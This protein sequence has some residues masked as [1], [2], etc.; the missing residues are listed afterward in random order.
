M[1]DASHG[2]QDIPQS[3]RFALPEQGYA[4]MIARVRPGFYGELALRL[5]VENGVV[6]RIR[7]DESESFK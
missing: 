4:K 5:I 7:L 1:V 6:T 2:R 3:E